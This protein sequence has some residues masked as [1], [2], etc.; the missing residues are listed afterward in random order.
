MANACAAPTGPLTHD[1]P[2]VARP[3]W[4]EDGDIVLSAKD[5]K[6]EQQFLVHRHMLRRT[7]NVFRDMLAMPQPEN[8]EGSVGHLVIP[9]D[10][11]AADLR[12]LLSALYDGLCVKI[13]CKLTPKH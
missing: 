2:M 5:G 11:S 10:D 7:S 12:A 6:I 8:A 4:H 3:M 9:L 1:E 13:S